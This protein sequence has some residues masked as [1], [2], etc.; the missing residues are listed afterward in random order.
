M[1]TSAA[2]AKKSKGRWQE[3]KGKGKSKGKSGKKGKKQQKGKEGKQ[4]KR[5]PQ[6]WV[7]ELGLNLAAKVEPDP[8]PKRRPNKT[9]RRG[10]RSEAARARQDELIELLWQ[11]RIADDEEEE[12]P[13]SPEEA[14][15]L[16]RVLV[17]TLGGDSRTGSQ[18]TAIEGPGCLPKDLFF[19]TS[20]TTPS[21]SPSPTTPHYTP[22]FCPSRLS[23]MGRNRVRAL[24]F[25]ATRLSR[26]AAGA[27]ASQDR[28]SKGEG[29]DNFI[30]VWDN[31]PSSL[32]K[33]R[34]NTELWLARLDLEKTT[35]YS[36]AARFLLRQTGATR[37]RG[38]EFD[39]DELAY[40]PG[41][42]ARL[43]KGCS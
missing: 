14:K 30:P 18:C 31:D 15:P 21:T 32:R 23:R 29:F 17:G 1:G 4:Q 8:Q 40:D 41:V 34:R 11:L 5:D 33:F 38:E 6:A 2:T 39:L 35:R 36:L 20:P 27:M 16:P 13:P 43:Q 22:I 3:S 24:L 19:A 37:A 25:V 7:D 42:V 26:P 28:D 10:G 12:E 9:K